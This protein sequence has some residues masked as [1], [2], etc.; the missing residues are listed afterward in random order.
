MPITT[1]GAGRY[2]SAAAASSA[3]DPS[4]RGTLITL[5]NGNQD[6]LGGAVAAWTSVRGALSHNTSGKYHFEIKIVVAAASD[7][8]MIGVEDA[9]TATGASMDDFTGDYAHSLGVRNSSRHFDGSGWFANTGTNN[10]PAFSNGD[11]V[12]VDLDFDNSFG[13]LALN[14]TYLDSGDPT[15]GATGTGRQFTWSGH[16][17]IAIF[18]AVALSNTTGKARL[19]TSGFT[20][21]PPSG[22]SGWG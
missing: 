16:P 3:W 5:S 12:S 11:V 13:Y 9:A 21:S 17:T 7:D 15:S 18:P 22:Y 6:A 4:G 20:F 1:T 14:N 10:F 19:V 2:L 8:M